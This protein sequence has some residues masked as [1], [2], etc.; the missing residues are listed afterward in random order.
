MRLIG[1]ASLVLAGLSLLLWVN[2]SVRG[3]EA[4]TIG[5][6]MLLLGLVSALFIVALDALRNEGAPRHDDDDDEPMILPR[7]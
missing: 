6:A 7:R 1:S 2:G 3:V 4:N 5:G